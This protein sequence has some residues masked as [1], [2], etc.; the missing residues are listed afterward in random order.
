M[1][2]FRADGEGTPPLPRKA[3]ALIAYLC[4]APGNRASRIALAT[5]LWDKTDERARRNLRHVLFDI[6]RIDGLGDLIRSD[7]QD[8]WLNDTAYWIDV[9]EEPDQ[10]TQPLL[11]D[12]DGV[13][14]GFHRWLRDERKQFEDRARQALYDRVVQLGNEEAS[15]DRRAAAAHKLL[16]FDATHEDGLCAL[17]KALADEGRYIQALREYQRFRSELW[18]A[19]EVR[20]SRQTVAIY[21]AIRLVSSRNPAKPTR[22]ARAEVIALNSEDGPANRGSAPAIAVL[23][24]N[25]LLGDPRHNGLVDSLAHDLSG[26]LSR[27]PGF[28]VTSHL[29]ARTFRNQDDRLPQD[30]GD[31]LDVRYILSG[32]LR[33]DGSRLYLNAELADTIKGIVLWSTGIEEAFS[34]FID[35][36]RRLAGEVVKQASPKLRMA[37]LNRIRGK[38]PEQLNAYDH[39][40]QAQENMYHFSPAVF[41]RAEGHFDAA[42]ARDPNFAA[43]LAARAHWHLLRIGQGWSRD[44]ARDQMLADQFAKRALES[45]QYEPMAHAIQGHIASYLHHDFETALD[46][47]AAALNLDPNTA[48]A[49]MWSAATS[50]WA[51]DGGAAVEKV[52]R[53]ASLSPYDPLMYFSNAVAGMA[54]L[55]DSQYERAVESAYLALRESR[56]YAAAHRLLVIALVLA[57]RPDDARSAAHRLLL[58]EPGVTVERFRLRFPGRDDHHTRLYCEA[59]REAGIPRA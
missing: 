57:G 7:Q 50:V 44:A 1:Q 47:F 59:L 29:T 25:N 54:Y 3:R 20:P 10:Y 36:P 26:L 18:D 32:A 52:T 12:L 53:A 21:E 30:I 56:N 8:I 19:F 46:F 58:V 2:V 43:V 39:F 37:E 14:E 34:N 40:L 17:M 9:L 5:L 45:D 15:P 33:V 51:G 24:F 35:V 13:S 6:D 11:D 42:L 23:P 28:F 4:L 27:L 49:W 48:H 16:N 31:L 22:P 41:A 55:A 38:H